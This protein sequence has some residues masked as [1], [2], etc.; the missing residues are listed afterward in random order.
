MANVISNLCWGSAAVVGDLVMFEGSSPVLFAAA[1]S[2]FA[3][4]LLGFQAKCLGKASVAPP[5]A[6]RCGVW[7]FLTELCYLLGLQMCGAITAA[8]WQPVTPL[9][10]EAAKCFVASERASWARTVGVV[11]AFVGTLIMSSPTGGDSVAANG[12]FFVQCV[13]M[14][15]YTFET[16]HLIKNGHEPLT[17]TV[18]SLCGSSILFAPTVLAFSRQPLLSLVCPADDCHGGLLLPDTALPGLAYFVVFGTALPFLLFAYANSGAID[19]SLVAVSCVLQPLTAAFLAWIL[20]LATSPPHYG[21]SGPTNATLLG[22]AVV[23]AGLFL[24]ARYEEGPPPSSSP[25]EDSQY[26]TTKTHDTKGPDI[27]NDPPAAKAEEIA[28]LARRDKDPP[29]ATDAERTSLLL[30][31]QHTRV[32]AAAPSGGDHRTYDTV[33]AFCCDPA[34]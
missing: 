25:K 26:L 5:Q 28:L 12:V 6:V 18:W 27:E 29:D 13:A 20:V 4:A 17:V 2:W 21:A 33:D 22:A 11:V 9:L 19:V 10:T 14:T 34:Q 31:H 30:S 15:A 8:A 16:R 1:R 23:L 24:V 3:L 7:L 32:S